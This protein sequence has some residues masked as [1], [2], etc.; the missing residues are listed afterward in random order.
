LI[1]DCGI[2]LGWRV[3]TISSSDQNSKIQ[4]QESSISAEKNKESPK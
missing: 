1:F 3:G 4:N 2:E